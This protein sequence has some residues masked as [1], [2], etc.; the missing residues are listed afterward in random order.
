M[1]EKNVKIKLF[2]TIV[3]GEGEDEEKDRVRL[4]SDG[5][6]TLDGDRVEIVYQELM[7]EDGY[8]GNTLSFSLADPNV[9]TIVRE[10]AASTVMTFSEKG[11]Y[12]ANYDVGFA[13]FEMIVSTQYISNGVSFEKGGVLRLDY[14]TEIQGVALQ[15]SRF[16]FD[17]T[18][19]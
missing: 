5:V 8:V 17:I 2:A 1:N 9:V 7:G 13:N 15:S 4:T 6:M 10:G 19:L 11:R 14:T 16:R 18:C 12:K 3:R